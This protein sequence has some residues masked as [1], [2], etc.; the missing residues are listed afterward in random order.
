[1]ARFAALPGWETVASAA[2]VAGLGTLGSLDLG[3][4]RIDLVSLPGDRSQRPLWGP[5]ASG[6]IGA[7][8]L[9]PAEGTEGLLL[10][11]TRVLRLPSVVAG[12]EGE[13]VPP[14]L[15]GAAADD[16]FE[17]RDAA[18]ALRA[19]LEGAARRSG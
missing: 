17:G 16:P 14:V 8:V 15:R 19:L 11:L 5:F 12:P 1:M 9:L 3:A 6:A 18:E 7:L 4:V 10:D 13:T 2:D